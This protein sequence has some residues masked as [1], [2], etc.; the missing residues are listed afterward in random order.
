MPNPD[1]VPSQ[2]PPLRPLH[3]RQRTTRRSRASPFTIPIAIFCFL[4][5]SALVIHINID[6]LSAELAQLRQ[7][8]RTPFGLA[9]LTEALLWAVMALVCLIRGLTRP[10]SRTVFY[11]AAV[12]LFL[13]GLSDVVEVRT[14]AWW[15]PWWLLLWK[16]LCVVTL[17][18]LVVA[19]HAL[20]RRK[21]KE[22]AA[23]APAEASPP[24]CSGSRP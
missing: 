7:Q 21:L 12:T 1:S 4:G 13:F 10:T 5:T 6:W 16:A 8:A 19:S 23:S 11:I 9:N 22:S 17:V 15:S 14:G 20:G 2:L 24:G 18:T 3:Y